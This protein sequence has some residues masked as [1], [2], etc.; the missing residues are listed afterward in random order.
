MHKKR[1]LFSK[2]FSKVTHYNE[3]RLALLILDYTLPPHRT[4]TQGRG[5]R[6]TMKS[7][8]V[9]GGYAVEGK[10]NRNL[11]KNAS[12]VTRPLCDLKV[13]KVKAVG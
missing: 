13:S 11:L 3:A 1:L 4:W 5:V 7:H 10:R 6:A 2:A 9:G 12:P 8:W